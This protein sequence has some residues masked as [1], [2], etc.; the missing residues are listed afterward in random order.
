MKCWGG[1]E[2]GE[3]GYGD[4][5]T[6]GMVAGDMGDNLPIVDLVR[7]HHDITDYSQV[8]RTSGLVVNRNQRLSD[9]EGSGLYGNQNLIM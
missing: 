8:N 7:I 6:R 1:C 4:T 3:C 2:Y 5:I 9:P